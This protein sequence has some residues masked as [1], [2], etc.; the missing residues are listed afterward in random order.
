[1]DAGGGANTRGLPRADGVLGCAHRCRNYQAARQWLGLLPSVTPQRAQVGALAAATATAV[2]GYP[3]LASVEVRGYGLLILLGMITLWRT[4]VWLRVSTACN[5]AIVALSMVLMFY[6]SYTALPFYLVLTLF[7][8]LYS[9]LARS[10]APLRRLAIG[11]M[12]IGVSVGMLI[13]PEALRFLRVAPEHVRAASMTIDPSPQL[14]QRLYTEFGGSAVSLVIFAI[15]AAAT[16]WLFIRNRTLRWLSLVMLGWAL[17]PFLVYLV[18]GSGGYLAT[19]YLWWTLPALVLLIGFATLA[20]S[21]TTRLVAVGGLALIAFLPVDFA[22]Y[23]VGQTGSPPIHTTLAWLAERIRPNDVIIQDPLCACGDA[24]VWDYFTPQYFP[25][26]ELP[27]VTEP[28]DHARVWYL[29]TE[30]WGYNETLHREITSWRSAAEFVGP[31]NFLLRLYEG[32]P[33]REGI[34]FGDQITFHGYTL[35][36]NRQTIGEGDTLRLKLWWSAAQEVSQDY[37]FSLAVLDGEGQLVA[38]ND[39]PPLSPN[40]PSRT[41]VWTPETAYEDTRELHL[42][43][44]LRGGNYTLVLAVYQWW[45]GVRLVPS[46]NSHFAVSPQALLTLRQFNATIY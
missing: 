39:A 2:M 32:P 9:L 12:A 34:S 3:I 15:A 41:S 11:W 17:L 38:Q 43:G 23:R 6:T 31:W 13:L 25:N 5:A 19:R 33:L 44:N 45:D 35:E 26:G 8:A 20:F 27:L 24:M 1:M 10:G 29:S 36:D 4:G 7:A 37:S 30:G 28:G 18:P 14:L 22:S 16:T 21:P 40:T 42:P 46:A